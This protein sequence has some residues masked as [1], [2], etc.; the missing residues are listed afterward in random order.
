MT[1]YYNKYIWILS[2]ELLIFSSYPATITS[3]QSRTILSSN[4]PLHNLIIKEKARILEL[5]QKHGARDVRVFGSMARNDATHKSD[6]DLLVD[7]E[8]GRDLF[9]L[10]AFQMDIQ[11]LLHRKVD[12][13][14]ENSLHLMI[15]DRVLSEAIKL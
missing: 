4:M 2:F 9:D 1:H 10:G 5:A 8:E 11:D 3:H 7:L 12:V 6:V 15:R 14:T 13:V